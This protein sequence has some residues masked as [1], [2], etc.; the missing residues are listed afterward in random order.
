MKDPHVQGRVTREHYYRKTEVRARLFAVLD[1]Q[2][3]DREMSLMPHISR[4]V[5]RG[6][7]L[8]LIATDEE[9]KTA[10]DSIDKIATIGFAEVAEAGLLLA[11]DIISI[12]KE[13]VGTVTGFDETHMPNHLNVA[14]SVDTRKTGKD[15]GYNLDAVVKIAGV[16]TEDD[17]KQIGF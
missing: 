13:E 8:E 1:W 5:R 14:I 2:V 6:D 3:D 16:A 9:G 11:G 12:D 10:G 15:A 17:D 7:I 4:A